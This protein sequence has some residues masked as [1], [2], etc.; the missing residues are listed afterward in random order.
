MT[1]IIFLN[2]PPRSGKTVIADHL[3]RVYDFTQANF[4]DSIKSVLSVLFPLENYEKF[5]KTEL[6]SDYTGRD[7]MIEFAES[8][9]KPKLGQDFFAKA[10]VDSITTKSFETGLPNVVIGDLG[11]D[12]E[13]NTA[14]KKFVLLSEML[15][16]PI[17]IQLW[18][19]IRN[20]TTF[21]KDSRKYV[22]NPT[23]FVYNNGTIDTL[24]RYVSELVVER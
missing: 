12:V 13:Y 5:K 11:F 2:G 6:Y 3:S 8:F 19:V 14:Y 24:T 23:H 21:E 9:I 16:T 7:F 20:G 18:R 15:Q 4:A 1:T 10:L 22:D 17:D